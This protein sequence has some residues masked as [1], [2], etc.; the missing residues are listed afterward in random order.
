MKIVDG[1]ILRQIIDEWVVVP[2]GKE[3]YGVGGSGMLSL[4]E[5]SALMW[6]QLEQGTSKIA[7]VDLLCHHYEVDRNTA[8]SDVNDFLQI[9]DTKQLLISDGEV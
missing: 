3:I 2:V 1:F 7:L 9:L 8:E 5:S 4:S 6:E